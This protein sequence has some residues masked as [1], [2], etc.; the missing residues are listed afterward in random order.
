M[1][2]FILM[3]VKATVRDVDD[4]SR[5]SHL[6]SMENADKNLEIVHGDLSKPGSYDAAFKNCQGV[7]HTAGVVLAGSVRDPMKMVV[8]PHINGTLDVLSS[9]EKSGSV[10]RLVHTSSVAAI[11]SCDRP[12]G[13]RFSEKDVNEW[14]RVENGD[15][16]GYAKVSAEKHVFEASSKSDAKFDAV[17]INPG[18]VFGHCYTKAHTKTSPFHVREVI[19]GNEQPNIF[20]AS[21]HVK[22]V[23]DAHVAALL[24]PEAAGKKFILVGEGE[25]SN[26]Y[27]SEFGRILSE[28]LPEYTFNARMMGNV[29]W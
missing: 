10:K 1:H 7:V 16:Y 19:Y 29:K 11:L 13:T 14:S 8:E 5:Y 4:K 22:D 9:I 17:C 2:H 24:L 27:L 25:E 15:H 23:A 26:V 3:Q 6:L 21:V 20:M 28:A 12:T 18:F